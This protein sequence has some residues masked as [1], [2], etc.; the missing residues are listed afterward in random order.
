[1]ES[2]GAIFIKKKRNPFFTYKGKSL[3]HTE[4]SFATGYYNKI[5]IFPFGIN[6]YGSLWKSLKA[7]NFVS[8]WGIKVSKWK[9]EDQGYCKA[10]YWFEMVNLRQLKMDLKNQNSPLLP[11]SSKNRPFCADWSGQLES[12]VARVL[13]ESRECN[14]RK[15]PL[16]G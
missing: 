5:C 6:G 12:Q 8:L 14:K 16:F 15:C 13:S 10:G 11:C 1:M 3:F 4:Y 9:D 2:N 7:F